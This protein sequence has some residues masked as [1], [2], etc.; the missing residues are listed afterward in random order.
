MEA[1]TVQEGVSE[2]NSKTITGFN[3]TTSKSAFIDDPAAWLYGNDNYEFIFSKVQI[4]S[5]F[6]YAPPT[7]EGSVAW[8][9][10]LTF[11]QPTRCTQVAFY[12]FAA[13]RTSGI[14]YIR[15]R[16]DNDISQWVQVL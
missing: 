3:Q 1:T 16:H 15:R 10:V 14:I 8:W 6:S 7:R 9:N 2:L 4:T 5:E 12:G 11:G 13:S